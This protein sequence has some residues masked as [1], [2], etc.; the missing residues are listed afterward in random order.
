MQDSVRLFFNVFD[1]AKRIYANIK[2]DISYNQYYRIL[3]EIDNET[4][5]DLKGKETGIIFGNAAS[6]LL[7]HIR[8]N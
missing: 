5:L 7:N 8:G 1:E 2:L 3:V 4:I 6:K